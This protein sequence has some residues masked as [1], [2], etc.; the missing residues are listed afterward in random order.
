MV[1]QGWLCIS[2]KKGSRIFCREKGTENYLQ[3]ADNVVGTGSNF[4][5]PSIDAK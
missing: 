4:P 3:N 5:V 1:R 2:V